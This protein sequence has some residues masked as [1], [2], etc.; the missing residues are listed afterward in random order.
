M[1]YKYKVTAFAGNIKEGDD[2]WVEKF[3]AQLEVQL[4]EHANQGWEFVGQY[5]FWV[6]FTPGLFLKNFG[7]KVESKKCQQLVF[8]KQI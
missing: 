2:D 1:K 3:R 6:N 4:E 7:S 8:R 5:E